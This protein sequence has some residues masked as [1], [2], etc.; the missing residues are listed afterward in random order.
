MRR[1]LAAILFGA[2]FLA[3]ASAWAAAGDLDPA[4]GEGGGV[5]TEV[6][7]V[8]NAILYHV[9]RQPDGKL[10]A[11][12][13]AETDGQGAVVGV[14]R[15]HPN[16]ALDS[17]FG[18]GGVVLTPFGSYYPLV[19]GVLVQPDG[20]IVVAARINPVSGGD[21]G[22][23]RYDADGGLDPTFG[24][25]GIVVTSL[26]GPAEDTAA[27]ALQPDGKIV[28]AADTSADFG[29]PPSGDVLVL[30][31][32]PDGTLDA[33]FGLGGVAT[34]DFGG[35]DEAT[36]LVLE[37][38]GAIVVAGFTWTA[39]GDLSLGS[40]LAVARLDADGVLDSGFGTAGRFF[41]SFG[42]QDEAQAIVR[43][44]AGGLLIAGASYTYTAPNQKD[45][46]VFFLRLTDAGALDGTFGAGGV[47]WPARAPGVGTLALAPD[48]K[49]VVVGTSG[50]G[51]FALAFG[52]ARYLA[53]GSPDLGFGDAG[54]A[55][56]LLDQTG[57]NATAGLVEPDG[58]IVAVGLTTETSP[59]QN[60]PYFIEYYFGLARFLG[61]SVPCASDA[62]CG[63]CESC[64][65]A[66]ACAFGPRAV[67][68]GAKP[69]GAKLRFDAP[70]IDRENPSRSL[71]RQRVQFKWI[72]ATPLGFD[73]LGSHDAGLCLYMNERR[74]LKAVAP[75]GGTCAGRPCWSGTP[76]SKLAYRDPERS[77]HGVLKVQL[78]TSKA[79]V[80]ARGANL[81]HTMH[82][83][84]HP[85]VLIGQQPLRVQVHGGNGV[86]LG[87]VLTDVDVKFRKVAPNA[88]AYEGLRGIGQ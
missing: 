27:V 61:A 48:G 13:Y 32:Q 55:S 46:A 66:G 23:L 80:E 6:D 44:S 28:V 68:T 30:R 10:V 50:T 19:E 35:R 40:S 25:G 21:I 71:E 22:L 58:N 62:D 84:P 34:I 38:G 73:P 54:L 47:V 56:A 60:P 42:K 65:A 5:L 14:A 15:Y 3:A 26:G 57:S 63:P 17:S 36:A 39:P 7:G 69:L 31:Y 74:V 86:C 8:E 83:I 67:C 82:G 78:G 49:I 53:D 33:G 81:T 51:A 16:G 12:G 2:P 29:G 43:T 72:G 18:T 52:V 37:P 11:A 20:R 79:V 24:S 1:T 9:A 41:H 77:P 75:A 88:Y 76:G 4:F 85:G 45:A 59:T 64:G 70:G 87:A